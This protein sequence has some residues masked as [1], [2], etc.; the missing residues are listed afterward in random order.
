M[1]ERAKG[2]VPPSAQAGVQAGAQ[3]TVHPCLCL[4]G[5]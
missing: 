2:G 4:P 5:L 1:P 3:A